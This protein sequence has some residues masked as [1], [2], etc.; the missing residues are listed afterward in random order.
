MGALRHIEPLG[1]VP[2]WTS[3]P[4]AV[5][6]KLTRSPPTP[7]LWTCEC[8]AALSPP[9]QSSRQPMRERTSA[10]TS[11]RQS[12]EAFA[13]STS[14]IARDLLGIVDN[15]N[16]RHAMLSGSMPP[17]PPIQPSKRCPDRV[18]AAWI[19]ACHASRGSCRCNPRQ[20][21]P[22]LALAKCHRQCHSRPSLA[23]VP[24]TATASSTRNPRRC[25][26]RHRYSESGA[27]DRKSLAF[28]RGT[29]RS[30]AAQLCG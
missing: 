8:D 24:G 14:P 12:L 25:H 15:Y 13:G 21:Y 1:K 9:T 16:L 10:K 6:L 17:R 11:C 2:I 5:E 30:L 7:P 28:D 27:S 19:Q 20:H 29:P 26:T 18:V 23:Q 22:V 3:Q 4:R